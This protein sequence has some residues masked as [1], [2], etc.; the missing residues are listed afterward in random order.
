VAF[1]LVPEQGCHPA[2]A[3][4]GSHPR[5]QSGRGRSAS[6]RQDDAGSGEQSDRGGER[7]CKRAN[8]LPVVAQA[9]LDAAQLLDVATDGAGAGG[10]NFLLREEAYASAVDPRRSQLAYNSLEL[11]IALQRAN[12]LTQLGYYRHPRGSLFLS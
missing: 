3:P 10:C 12:D 1:V 5:Q 6:C 9:D 8:L 2:H 7:G 4:P 11:N